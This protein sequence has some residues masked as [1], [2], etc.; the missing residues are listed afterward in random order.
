MQLGVEAS[1]I[2]IAAG[3]DAV[4]PA[5]HI[6]VGDEVIAYQITGAYSEE[7]V[8]AAA[9]VVPKPVELSWEQAATMMLTGT[10]AAHVL[11]AVR[12]RR[13]QTVLVHGAG[14]V[15]GLAT[16][17]LARLDDINVVGTV[18]HNGFD[19]L[20]HVGCVPALALNQ[21]FECSA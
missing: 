10:T 13:G 19:T 6:V 18:G 5:G 20:R 14:G 3:A 11:A 2:V 16:V 12:A 17:Q 15:V 21:S 4:G 1:G 9:D 7:I 8:V